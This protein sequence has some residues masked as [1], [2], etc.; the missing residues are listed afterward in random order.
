M[1]VSQNGWPADPDPAVVGIVPLTVD[2][3]TVGDGVRGGDVATPMHPQG[4]RGSFTPAQAA[5]VREL[6]ASYGGAVR[7]GGDY[8][9]PAVVDEMHFEIN[10]DPATLARVAA[11]LGAPMQILD[12]SAG[13]P[14]GAAVAAAGYSGVI[15][16]LRK[17]GTSV[18]KPITP[19][20]FADMQAHLRDVALIYQHVQQA[21]PQA[22]R[23]AG[24]HD[25]QWAHARALEL[26]GGEPRAIYFAVDFDAV[27]STVADYFAGCGD[28]LGVDQV[29]VYGSYRVAQ[30]LLDQGLVRWAWQCTAWSHG[31]VEPRAHLYQRLG[32]VTVGG[33]ACDVNDVLAPDY[34]QY[35]VDEMND[36]DR[37]MLFN[38]DAV[39][40]AFALGH[41]TVTLKV[42]DGKTVTPQE[43]PMSNWRAPVDAA[44]LAAAM[45]APVAA[46][47]VKLG[48]AGV[49]GE[50]VARAFDAAAASL[51]GKAI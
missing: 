46:E 38:L 17:E 6:V 45:A 29:G 18:V 37:R 16:Y 32:T 3:V 10:T 12:Y 39:N 14:G 35:G 9:A 20:E 27:P 19:A 30:Y 31:A 41:D 21:R 7:W 23:P 42:S 22:G 34:G 11:Q 36:E 50:A 4:R 33:V 24:V 15:R 47:L 8:T 49:T 28:Q 5:I 51:H 48:V 40:G 26:G 44:A 1:T 43:F 25:A 13:Y 2:G